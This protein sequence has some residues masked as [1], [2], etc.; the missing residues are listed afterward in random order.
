MLYLLAACLLILPF[1][2][3]TKEIKFLYVFYFF[4]ALAIT[5][6]QMQQPI[7]L[8]TMNVF[9]SYKY[10]SVNSDFAW[11]LLKRDI[12]SYGVLIFLGNLFPKWPIIYYLLSMIIFYICIFKYLKACEYKV[13]SYWILYIGGALLV[14]NFTEIHHY[15][16]QTVAV[17]IMLYGLTQKKN[18][19][20]YLIGLGAILWHGSMIL[21]YPLVFLLDMRISNKLMTSYFLLLVLCFILGE[22]NIYQLLSSP[23]YSNREW[24]DFSLIDRFLTYFQSPRHASYFNEAKQVGNL[25]YWPVILSSFAL[26]VV[27]QIKRISNVFSIKLLMLGLLYLSL[28]RYHV[29]VYVRIEYYCL[30]FLFLS[31]VELSATYINSKHRTALEWGFLI[32]CL[33]KIHF[34]IW[35]INLFPSTWWDIL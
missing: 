35:P 11:A 28:F 31:I 24:M 6:F 7:P 4:C 21:F 33:L 17:S 16:R 22:F 25:E 20:R 1:F 30:I 26:L 23:A 32:L 8:D 14:F 18:M 29:L 27:C 19:P 12:L 5:I 15:M 10:V 9:N 34:F 13:T 3:K 2:L